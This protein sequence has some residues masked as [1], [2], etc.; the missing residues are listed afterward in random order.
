MKILHVIT[1][2]Y[3]G[4]AERLMLDLLPRL[5]DGDKHQVDLLLFNGVETPFK[6]SIMNCGIDVNWL[7]MTN[8]V[9]NPNRIIRMR[10]FLNGYDVIHTHNTACQTFVPLAKML[11]NTSAK[12][13]T[14][15]HSSNN[16]RRSKWWLKPIDRWMYGRYSAIVCI[17][18]ISRHNL[19]RYVGKKNNIRLIP[20]GV[21]VERFVRPIKDITGQDRFEITMVAALRA[22]K[23]HETML[24]AMKHLPDNYHL[25]LVGGGV[26]NAELKALVGNMGLDE[27]VT[28]MG[29]RMDVPDL[30]E[31]SDINVL[32]SHWEGFGLVAVEGM[33][34][35]RPFVASDVDGLH[36]VVGGAGLL[37]PP[38]DDLQ[39]ANEIRQ[40]CENPQEY[41]K[42]ASRCQ[43]RAA[44]YDVNETARAYIDLYDS[45][46]K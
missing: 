22:E 16:W 29:V 31:Q 25:R 43:E 38:G 27:R 46:L 13:V 36:D 9:Y 5:N 15:E 7:A 30:L 18:D 12:L 39:L 23:D 2:L 37:F 44:Q 20:N 28:F 4:G 34:S 41:R 14:T 3:T 35:G 6:K 33:A 10:K 40:L 42:V 1:S 45:M 24:N 17:S 8:D 32:S 21:D 19:E 26:R 11:T